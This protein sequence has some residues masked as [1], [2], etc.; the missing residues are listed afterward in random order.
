MS[1]GEA[2]RGVLATFSVEVN[3]KELREADERVEGF[4]E[5]LSTVGHALAEAFAFHE[6]KEF[7]EGQVEAG[8]ALKD[9]SERIGTTTDE[10]QAYELAASQAGVSNEGLTTSLRFLNKN[11]AEAAGG[12][13]EAS[14]IFSQ[15]GIA[16]KEQDGSTRAAGDVMGD[17]ADAVASIDDP[18]RQTEVAMKLLGRGGAELIP[19][20]KQGGAAFEEA[21]AQMQALGGGLSGEF[22]AQAKEADD[23]LARLKFATTGLKSELAEALLPVLRD[24]VAW[25][26]RAVVEIRQFQRE[27]GALSTA[28]E[29]FGAIAG[30]KALGT[31][32]EL[33]K[34]LGILKGSLRE[35][36]VAFLE[37]AAPAVLIG[38]LYLAFD[39]LVNLLKGND[40]LI[41]R[42]LGPDK[43]KFVTELQG[44]IDELK[45][46]FEQLTG[47]IGGGE[48]AWG[49]F[50]T[51]VV[52][53]GKALAWVLDLMNGVIE[54][55]AKISSAFTDLF[56]G[57]FDRA[58]AGFQD[59][60]QKGNPN[61][62][63]VDNQELRQTQADT[64]EITTRY[65]EQQ[66]R[67]ALLAR[68]GAQ[69]EQKGFEQGTFT[70]PPAAIPEDKATLPERHYLTYPSAFLP[71]SAAPQPFD[72]TKPPEQTT[73]ITQ[74]N[75]FNVDVKTNATDG[76]GTAKA[77]GPGL[78]NA[79]QLANERAF[80]SKKKP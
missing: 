72:A 76:E 7:I 33:A 28:A 20:L 29:F 49:L 15:L 70:G 30:L 61:R 3:D 2:L 73:T 16:I 24:G 11:L 4:K 14:K 52:D 69:R 38:L 57:R 50:A 39:D 35:T 51:A 59:I 65:R 26:T 23:E 48:T 75:T 42:M 58:V 47:S 6:V 13:G 80:R 46:S 60:G 25:F 68:V 9:T 71:Q 74:Q 41:G 45:G 64:E 79:Q 62:D 18:A 22:I 53:V 67:N 36:L 55:G 37:F 34:T 31:L 27:T 32:K 44:A 17:L 66:T 21:R 56:G 19:L 1:F 54:G 43:Q 40:S 78:A 10:L 12:G 5:T 8:A 77:V 63:A